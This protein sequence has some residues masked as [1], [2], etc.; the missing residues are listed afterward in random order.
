MTK[1][2]G[3]LF[4]FLIVSMLMPPISWAGAPQVETRNFAISIDGKPAGDYHMTIRLDN[5]LYLISGQADVKVRYLGGVYTYVYSY[6]GNEVWKDGRLQRLETASNDNGKK[7]SVSA[8]VDGNTLRVKVN[9]Q[10]RRCRPDVWTTSYWFLAAANFR[11]QAVP[12][13]DVDTGREIAAQLQFVG[14]SAIK[15][16]GKVQNCAQYRL[17]GGVQVD[18]WF[19]AQERLVR[20]EMVEDGHRTVLELK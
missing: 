9:G 2:T 15:V 14:N 3:K 5:G 20:E 1:L 7:F 10:E 12:L 6:N 13:L 4:G 19:D 8:L 16:S 11:N 17:R 18:L